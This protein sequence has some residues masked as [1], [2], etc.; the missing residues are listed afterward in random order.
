MVAKKVFF[1]CVELSKNFVL[2]V[3]ILCITIFWACLTNLGEKTM[4]LF[5]VNRLI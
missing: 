1:V 2:K 4:V 5:N 3:H